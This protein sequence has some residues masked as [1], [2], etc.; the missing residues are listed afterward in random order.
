[1]F[2]ADELDSFA[3]SAQSDPGGYLLR[4]W[5]SHMCQNKL[6]DSPYAIQDGRVEVD[7]ERHFCLLHIRASSPKSKEV[8]T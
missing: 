8:G 6:L 2:E 4:Q 7:Q 5:E 1:L 3:S